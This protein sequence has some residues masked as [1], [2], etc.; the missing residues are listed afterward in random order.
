MFNV[1]DNDDNINDNANNINDKIWHESLV[2]TRQ[3][4]DNFCGTLVGLFII[5]VSCHYALVCK[6]APKT[7]IRVCYCMSKWRQNYHIS[8][9]VGN[10]CF[11]QDSNA[12]C[13]S[14]RVNVLLGIAKAIQYLHSCSPALIHGDIKRWVQE[15]VNH[16]YTGIQNKIIFFCFWFNLPKTYITMLQKIHSNKH[17]SFELL[18]I[19]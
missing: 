9:S 16:M 1:S 11:F 18:F 7:V 14:Q 3:N 17:C 13:W 10:T 15:H 5:F 2:L 4:M 12:L 19:K 6:W 8:T